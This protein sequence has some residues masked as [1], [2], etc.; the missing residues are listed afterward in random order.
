MAWLYVPEL[1]ESSWGFESLSASDIALWVTSSGTLTQ[2]P[3]SWRGWK[4][5][6]WVARLFGTIF[7]PSTAECIAGLWISSL[8]ASRASRTALQDNDEDTLTNER[9]G[10]NSAESCE[11]SSPDLSFLK[12][13]PRSSSISAQP[14]LSFDDWVSSSLRRCYTPARSSALPI[15]D[16]GYSSSLP[17]PTVR[18]DGRRGAPSTET[19]A[20]RWEAGRRNLDDALA[21]LPTPSA[22]SYGTNRGGAAGR[23]GAARPSLETLARTL[24][25]PTASDSRG[26]GAAGYSTSS[27]R[28]SGTT[29]S[30]AICG[31]ASAGRSGR[32]NPRFVE[33]MMGLPIG[34]TDCTASV[35]ESFRKWLQ[36]HSYACDGN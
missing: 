25:T 19:A 27:G 7:Q 22:C 6:P 32:L 9:S 17:T 8:A 28:H 35:T 15:S 33:W 34:W 31:A 14:G 23:T 5:R 13:C 16:D 1:E 36:A 21:L 11:K 3:L 12:T 30:D 4:T 20:K 29:L 2:R 18:E 26:S 24:P 10:H